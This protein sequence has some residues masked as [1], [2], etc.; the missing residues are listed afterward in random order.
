M[1]NTD[2]SFF[3]GIVVPAFIFLIA[4]VLSIWLY[5]TF[6]RDSHKPEE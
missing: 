3:W 1:N 5:R 4:F 2:F 6:S